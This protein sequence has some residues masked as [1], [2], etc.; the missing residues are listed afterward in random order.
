MEKRK[1]LI[2]YA[3]KY[4]G[5]WD[6][7]YSAICSKELLTDEE[8]SK[9]NTIKSKAITILDDEYPEQL[10]NVHKPPIVLF[11]YGDI[12][13]MRD[14]YK[15]ISI[16]G[17][18]ACSDYG[19]RMTEEIASD[20]AKRGYVIVS[21]MA[22]GIDGIAHQSAI[23]SGGKTIAVLGG[24]I[25]YCYPSE[26]IYLY[27]DIKKHH[28]LISEYPGNVLPQTHF[29]PIRNRIIAGLSKTL[30]VTE[31]SHYSGSLVTASLA[32]EGNADVMCVPYEAGKQS[33]CNRLINSGAI[34]VESADD[35]VN[36]MSTCQNFVK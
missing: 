13:L 29:F 2:A 34:L 22:K 20:L 8:E 12:S 25:D 28:L 11:Y 19:A 30:I 24:G 9:A 6:K 33:E 26:N 15:N 32:L 1:I 16:V 17:S 35:V 3:L 18:R 31:A 10:K 21:G 14:Y 36:E 4:E 7:I 5:D 27:K 23:N